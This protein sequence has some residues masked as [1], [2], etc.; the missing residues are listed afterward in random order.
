MIR[1]NCWKTMSAIFVLCAAMAIAAPAQ[2][3]TTL[4]SFDGTNGANPFL[5][6]LVQGRDGS[7]YGATERGG[8]ATCNLGCGTVFK[9]TGVGTLETLYNFCEQP[10][11]TD[12]GF[13]YAGLLLAADGNFYGTTTTGGIGGGTVFK[14]TSAG[15]LTTLHSFGSAD[16]FSPFGALIQAANGDLYGT[17]AYG[18]TN[19]AAPGCGTVFKISPAGS[20]TTLHNFDGSHG[21]LPLG[22]LIQGTN[23][24]FYGTTYQGG[25]TNNG[26]IFEITPD[27][28]LRTLHSFNG[29]DGDSPYAGLI[30]GRDRN[31]YGTSALGGN[32][33]CEFGCGTVFMM[34]PSGALT[35]L[36]SFNGSDG[37]YP[38]AGLIQGT[39]GN[40][41]GVTFGGGITTTNGTVFEITQGDK[42]ITL[43]A[44]NGEDGANSYGGL[45]QGTNGGF[46]GATSYG[47]A[48][49]CGV[50]AC[51]TVYKLDLDLGPFVAV[52]SAAGRI[53][54]TG[55]ILGQGFT[56]T[57][58]V[59][60]NGTPATY[61]VV[62]D[63]F[64]RATVPPGATT[65]F[66]TVT[67]P[68]GTL[69]SNVP[70][71]VIP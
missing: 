33:A 10:A 65:G 63:T 52:V 7:F 64:I 26:T 42:L 23:G 30:Q 29:S 37:A 15:A 68:S 28:T 22:G 48:F 41:Y 21:A 51:G 60:L 6:S 5:M 58:S 40:L 9:I 20:L 24:H 32:S 1:H 56:G 2:T 35:T 53:G 18:G 57:T 66:V 34:S 13:P 17:T 70:F 61:T 39:D 27:G 54:Q 45:F 14:I 36:H 50:N 8:N 55:G 19:C 38:Y 31:L 43:H 4:V 11:C 69:T 46:Y 12:G 49:E 16:G 44:F 67:T 59:S 47:G 62:S 71:R 25:P 3:F